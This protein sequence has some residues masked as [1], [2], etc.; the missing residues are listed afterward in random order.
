MSCTDEAIPESVTLPHDAERGRRRRAVRWR[1]K[2]VSQMVP[3]TQGRPAVPFPVV[4][5]HV[6]AERVGVLHSESLT[7]GM[8]H[9]LTVPR[10]GLGALTQQYDV[11][12][13]ER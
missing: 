5:E 10:A 11:V 7:V 9:L 2:F 3:W 13:C 1:R 6:S 4:V 8:R 12:E